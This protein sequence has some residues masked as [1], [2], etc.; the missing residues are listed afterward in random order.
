[1]GQ[2]QEIH[3]QPRRATIAVDERMNRHKPVVCLARERNRMQAGWV[4]E[5]AAE[6]VHQIGNL[7]RIRQD[8]CRA[9]DSHRYI[10]IPSGIPGIDAVEHEFV[11]FEKLLFRDAAGLPVNQ[12][13]HEIERPRVV[14]RLEMLPE[15]LAADGEALFDHRG[16]LAARQCVALQRVARVRELDPKPFR[17]VADHGGRQRPEP[18]EHLF[19]GRDRVEIHETTI[20]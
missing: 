14:G 10:A 18:V 9:G 15:T 6:S 7:S 17:Q 4:T 1:M 2:K 3:Q 19:L 5:P 8:D 13:H 16:R 11:E 12:R 20:T